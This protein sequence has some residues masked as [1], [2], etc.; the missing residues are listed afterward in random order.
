MG[1]GLN[2]VRF[3]RF[4]G[5]GIDGFGWEEVELAETEEGFEGAIEDARGGGLE[6]VNAFEGVLIIYYGVDVDVTV[7]GEAFFAVDC[8]VLSNGI[9]PEFGCG[10]TEAAGLPIGADQLIDEGHLFGGG[11]EAFVDT[12]FESFEFGGIFAGDDFGFGVDAGF[13]GVHG[14][15]GAACAGTWS[16]ASLRVAS[17]G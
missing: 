12:G 6:A 3:V 5:L 15:T 8:E 4:L 2:W 11:L 17:I 10:A 1:V 13:G 7:F 16:G 14:G 9:A